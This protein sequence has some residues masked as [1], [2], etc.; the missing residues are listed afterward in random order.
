MKSTTGR[1]LIHAP[2]IHSGGGIHLLR[3]LLKTTGLKVQTAQLDSRLENEPFVDVNSVYWIRPTIYRRICA[4]WNL[5]RIA[6][7]NDKVFCFHGLPPIFR[8][9]GTV[10]ILIQNRLL[11]SKDKLKGYPFRVKS[12]LQVERLWIRLLG[13]SSYTYV[14]QT[15]SMANLLRLALPNAKYINVLPFASSDR[16]TSVCKPHDFDFDFFYPSSADH[17]KNH[18][19]LLEAWKLLALEGFRPT[20][21]LTVDK[22]KYPD[23]ASEIE[24]LTKFHG[25]KIYNLG[26][27]EQ[28]AAIQVMNRSKAIIFPSFLE[29]LGLPLIEAAHMNIPI[30]APELDYVRD[31][32]TPAETFDPTSPRSIARAVR[33]AL[34]KPEPCVEI[35][36]TADFIK[37]VIK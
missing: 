12:R 17:H 9:Q 31:V 6:S 22:K 36:S 32:I 34:D 18:L 5:R 10:F 37:A 19:L 16:H 20:L 8:V 11:L 21:A 1:L 33:R 14:V 23:I 30:L 25:L 27:L 24:S 29:S 7:V 35:L 2:G 4:E 28:S 13:R 26:W 3:A 15:P